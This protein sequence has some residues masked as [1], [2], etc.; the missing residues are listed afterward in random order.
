MTRDQYDRSRLDRDV[1]A[2]EDLPIY[3]AYNANVDAVVR[4]DEGLESFLVRPSDPGDRPPP[5]RISSRRDLAT[6]ITRTMAAGRGDEVAMTDAFAAELESELTPDAQQ[7]GG[8]AGIMTN[9]LASLGAAP[10]VYTYL[11][12]ERQ[13]SMFTSPEEIRYPVVE[14]DTVTYAPLTEA[15]DT[16]RT[17]INWVFEFRDGDELFGVR[18]T[19]DTRF[20]AASRPPEFD[21]RAGA[22]DGAVDRIGADVDGALLAGYHNLTP[23]IVDEG[24][25]ETLRHARDVVRRL[26]SGGDLP[27][28]VEYAVTHDEALRR[29]IYECVLPEADVIGTDTHELS[30]LHDDA[31]HEVAEE[32]PTEE[33][34]FD[35]REILTHHRMISALLDELG[36]DCIRVH[37]MEYHLAVMDSYLPPDA[38][39]RGL[40]FA[41]INA[42][43]KASRGDVTSPADLETGLEYAP[44]ER[45]REA[46][47]RL[48]EAVG[49]PVRNGVLASP[50]VVACPNRV[51][52][53]PAGTVG[54]GDVVSSS[55]FVREVAVAND[56]GETL[57]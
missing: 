57:G 5:S 46:V 53:D 1:A 52:E 38:V 11:V 27:V 8:Q 47:E 41:A 22:V 28:H 13:L 50:S 2:L 9:L 24:Y 56:A 6:A 43:T 16:D 15:V 29:S 44:S 31:E 7:L 32:V 35:P 55:S 39:R 21:L 33:T 17:K 42:A 19:D 45:G 18:A 25:E 4:V 23:D 12:S 3:V 40:E 34:P 48:G 37:A 54:I 30:I 26:R 14:D 20:I 49:E 10:I 36:V 51:V